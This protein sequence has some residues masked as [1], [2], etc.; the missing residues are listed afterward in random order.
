M[1]RA[2]QLT[3]RY[4][5]E[6]ERLLAEIRASQAE[7]IDKAATLITE[8]VTQG[9]SCHVYDT[10]HMLMHE[11]VG[12]AGG[13]LLFTPILTTFEVHHPARP[14]P[15]AAGRPRVHMDDLD[16]LARVILSQS[17]CVEGD[18][19]IIG[20]VSGVSRLAVGLALEARGMGLR[21]IAL[22]ST[23]YSRALESAHPTG[24]R[25]FELADVVL[26]HRTPVGDATVRVDELD[27]SI[28]PVSGIAAAYLMW[29]LAARVVEKMVAAGFLPSVLT[30]NHLP[31]AGER[32]ARA[33]RRFAELGY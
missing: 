19:L 16:G 4:F 10:G 32:N 20:S 23:V 2:Q 5:Q 27:A 9:K 28:C 18:V 13:L 8:A 26:D 31:G 24:K 33:R 29:A 15:E 3:E 22:T 21:L 12:R 6:I 1:R 25:L 11:M 17:S 7:A 14:R 30:S